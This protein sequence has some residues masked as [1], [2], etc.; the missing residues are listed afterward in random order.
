MPEMAAEYHE[1][2]LQADELGVRDSLRYTDW[3]T[4]DEMPA[5][6]RSCDL[7]LCLG[8]IIE[9]FGL[10]AYESIACGTPVVATNVGAYRFL[11]DVPGVHRVDFGDIDAAEH[12]AVS[13]ISDPVETSA[14]VA[15]MIT[16]TGVMTGAYVDAI[17]RPGTY[18]PV[19]PGHEVDSDARSFRLA[20]WCSVAGDRIYDDYA[21]GYR[22]MPALARFLDETIRSTGQSFNNSLMAENSVPANEIEAALE[23]NVLI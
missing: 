21:Y 15:E 3:K 9:S 10:T 6:F 7:T 16:D 5:L 1:I 23:T 17:L 18:Q 8:N 12:A 20:P 22:D 14:G 4:Q 13:A 19:Y 11:P 2:E